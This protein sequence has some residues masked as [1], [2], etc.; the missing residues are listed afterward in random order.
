MRAVVIKTAA[1]TLALN[2]TRI[3]ARPILLSLAATDT[4]RR[5]REYLQQ[6][7]SLQAE[8]LQVSQKQFTKHFIQNLR[9][10]TSPGF[11]QQFFQNEKIGVL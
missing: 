2:Y 9:D 11:L 5:K 10:I 4:I 1:V 7:I 3:S 6:K 8:R